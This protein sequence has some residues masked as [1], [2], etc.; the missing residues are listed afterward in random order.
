[1]V[2]KDLCNPAFVWLL[3]TFIIY[4]I[5]FILCATKR[6]PVN[7]M[8]LTFLLLGIY[9]IIWT[10]LIDLA[11]KYKRDIS[12]W[13]LLVL[14]VII[15]V[16]KVDWIRM[17][18][19]TM[20]NGLLYSDDAYEIYEEENLWDEDNWDSFFV[21]GKR[22]P[23]FPKLNIDSSHDLNSYPFIMDNPLPQLPLPGAPSYG[24]EMRFLV[25]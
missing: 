17:L 2:L 18:N 12:A 15:A 19:K 13:F 20:T 21:P 10:I 24:P 25:Q 23:G 8:G 4:I 14:A 7:N 6:C 3:V 1:M 11:C 22:V 9:I 5:Y 16:F